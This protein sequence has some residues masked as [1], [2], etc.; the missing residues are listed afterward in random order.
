MVSDRLKRM[1]NAAGFKVWPTEV[2]SVLY[3]HPAVLEA[4]V[5][6]VPDAERVENVK[7]LVVLKPEAV[8]KVSPEEIIKWS[9]GE[10][11]AYKYPRMVE[12]VETLPKSGAGKVLWRQL[13]EEELA[14][15]Q[16]IAV[17]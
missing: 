14:K 16:K 4:C 2:E 3:R 10:M 12:I 5:I 9:K 13:Q 7:A 1:I 15:H 17:K 8:G 6:S 11:S